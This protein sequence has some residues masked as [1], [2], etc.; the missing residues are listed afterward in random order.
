MVKRFTNAAPPT[1][2]NWREKLKKIE[3]LTMIYTGQCP[4]VTRFIEECR[5]A[6]EEFGLSAEFREL[7]TPREAQNSPSLNSSFALIYR[8]KLLADRYISVT[9]FKNILKKDVVGK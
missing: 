3:A 2:N 1:F 7:K 6:L 9:R 4:W 8:G 5:G